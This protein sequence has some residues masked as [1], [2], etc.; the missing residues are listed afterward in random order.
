MRKITVSNSTMDNGN[1]VVLSLDKSSLPVSLDS[2]ANDFIELSKNNKTLPV[3]ETKVSFETI[4]DGQSVVISGTL[5]LWFDKTTVK[6]AVDAVEAAK[7]EAARL[8]ELEAKV[9]AVQNMT[10]EELKAMVLGNLD[11]L[12]V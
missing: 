6:A 5:A 3:G 4:I 11:K 8:A 10:P 9:N 7:K 12:N 2:L 1:T